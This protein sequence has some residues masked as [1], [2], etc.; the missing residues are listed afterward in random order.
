M[1]EQLGSRDGNYSMIRILAKKKQGLSIC[2]INAQSLCNKLDEFRFIFENSGVDAICVSETWFRSDICDSLYGLNGYRV[3]RSDRRKHAGGVAIYVRDCISCRFNCSY[4]I[5]G[6]VEYIFVDLNCNGSTLLLGCVY[7]PD[8][9]VKFD[10]LM[11]QL[12]LL[13]V[14]YSDVII[15]G[16]F[17]S[18]LLVETSLSE[19]MLA[20]HLLP[21]NNSR[22]TH[23]SSTT[24]TLLDV[25]FVSNSKKVLLY[26]QLSAPAFSKHDIIFMTY[27]FSMDN[28][29]RQFT[30]RD[31]NN[32]NIF[33]LVSDLDGILWDQIFYLPS[34]DEQVSF[35]NKCIL[36]LYNKHVPIITKTVRAR[37]RPWFNDDIKL[38]IQRRDIKYR[39][40]KR[41][42]IPVFYEEYRMARKAVAS[43][44]RHE[45]SAY[46]SNKFN[47][48]VDMNKTWKQIRDIGIGRTK[49]R[50]IDA[51]VNELNELFVNI[52]MPTPSP[53]FYS[54]I[55]SFDPAILKFSFR[56]FTAEDVVEGFHKVKSNSVGLD[57]INPRFIKLILPWIIRSVVHLFNTIII[58]STFPMEWKYAKV[59]P[60]PKTGCEYR[61]ISI[62]PYLSKV[63]EQL[64]Q[65]QIFKYVTGENLLTERQSGF[66]PQHSCVTALTDVVEDIRGNLDTGKISMLVLLDH[67]KAFDTVDHSLLCLKL[68]K[69]FNFSTTAVKLILSYLTDRLQSVSYDGLI[70]YPLC[71]VRGVPQGSILGPLL[72]SLYANDIPQQLKYSSIQM[73]ADDIQIY[74]SSSKASITSCVNDLNTD[75][76]SIFLWASANGLRLNP[77]KSKCLIICKKSVK[78]ESQIDIFLGGTKID[79]VSSVRNL[80]VIF[81][82]TL[83]WSDHINRSCG[84][85]Y[86]MLRSLWTTQYY[87]PLKIR[88]LLAKTYIL[89]TLLYSSEVFYGCNSKDTLKLKTTFN[90]VVRYIY[91]LKKFDHISQYSNRIFGMTFDNYL[92]QKNLVLLHKIVMTKMPKYLFIRLQFTRSSRGNGII[93]FRHNDTASE[94]QFFIL[95]IRLW[96]QLPAYIQN[97]SNAIKFKN[98]LSQL[99]GNIL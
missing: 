47:S 29:A 35:L 60:V 41:Y 66:R 93:Q 91:G 69:I 24:C 65:L 90:N 73:Y 16:D 86:C 1:Y 13:S 9:T 50:V 97:T 31:F 63:F 56:C 6:D 61:P 85:V 48:A 15:A 5:T 95:T 55:A 83:T 87:T 68:S 80:G 99:Y 32:I 43:R 71:V 42:R 77:N 94:R 34:P 14:S 64:L 21:V 25:L 27:D 70:S 45:K 59:I 28:P 92:M 75:L 53:D 22:P 72:F 58:T 33:N 96:N 82:N 89:P 4:N 49:S 81:N 46:Y 11:A 44:I 54:R 23:F 7:R 78:I 98:L 10:N 76:D 12:E 39:L 30:Y 67:S 84:R 52:P 51:N 57:D 88:L 38:L 17:N 2:H 62:L 79:I 37:A 26:D 18:N 8:K 36:Y 40:W 74:L 19:I 20:F 3:F